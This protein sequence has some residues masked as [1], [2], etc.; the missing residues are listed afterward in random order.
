MPAAMSELVQDKLLPGN[1]ASDEPEKVAAAAPE[2][3]PPRQPKSSHASPRTHCQHVRAPSPPAFAS[4]LA[5]PSATLPDKEKI[6][7]Y[8]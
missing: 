3:A 1:E 6:S 8:I 7:K 2:S 4:R 5:V